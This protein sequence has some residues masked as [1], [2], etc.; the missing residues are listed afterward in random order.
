MVMN[1]NPMAEKDYAAS[2]TPI[3][4]AVTSAASWSFYEGLIGSLRN[5]GFDPFLVS[6]PG[7][8]LQRIGQRAGVQC[9]A[10]PMNRET[11]P[12][13]D[14]LSLWRLF[15]IIR[16][17]RPT[18]TNVGTP[19]A[20]LLAGLAAWLSGVPCRIYTLHG[21]RLETTKGLRRV[22]LTLTE[23]IACSCAHRVIC[24]SPSLRRRAIELKL[25]SSEK[26]IVLGSGSSGGV[27][28]HRFSPAVRDSP[29]K[30]FLAEQLGIPYGVPV[31]GF[32]GRFTRDK[33]IVEL[34]AAFKQL[35]QTWTNLRLLLVGE[36]EDGDP[37]PADIRS[38]M[39]S[40]SNIVR[41]G[42][43]SNAAPY[44]GLM[45]VLVLPTYREGF[46]NVSI[47]AQ[48]CCVPVVTTTATG[49]I[50]SIA[51]GLTGFLVPVGSSDSLA[52][53]IGE[54]LQDPNMRVRMGQAGRDR[55]M[56]E[57]RQEKVYGA[58]V[59]EYRLLLR[60]IA[61]EGNQPGF[62]HNEKCV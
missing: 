46:G 15:R 25:A 6:S 21:L 57:F 9:E 36:F 2:R 49:A 41:A 48:A 33:G 61:L 17:V 30:D 14:L 44:Y 20:G 50:D 52:T 16:R 5:A 10:V 58:V 18:I 19:K 29:E 59:E 27:D 54:L 40:D 32:V 53:R 3:L 47:E 28:V 13:R 26:T 38:K 51:D 42:H 7:E 55:I 35:Q 8:K 62:T 12:L 56:R 60:G 39:E 31:I 45:D 4:F 37:V 23:K 24:V 43:V 1:E 11:A 34:M 22:L